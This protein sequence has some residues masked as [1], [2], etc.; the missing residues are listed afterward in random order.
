MTSR[1]RLR[2]SK[3][4]GRAR[5]ISAEQAT[6]DW[7][8]SEVVSSGT[9]PSPKQPRSRHFSVVPR[10]ITYAFILVNSLIRIG[11]IRLL[12]SSKDRR[13]LIGYFNHLT[14]DCLFFSLVRPT[15][16][17]YVP[18]IDCPTVDAIITYSF[19]IITA[20][21]G[22]QTRSCDE[23]SV[24]LSVRRSVKHVHCDK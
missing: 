10:G 20:L 5:S 15:L 6:L 17:T 7:T 22:M 8:Q 19:Y 24:R 4:R 1:T 16:V 23:I 9:D 21:H 12:L 14:T 3:R 13:R 18:L 2:R 11:L